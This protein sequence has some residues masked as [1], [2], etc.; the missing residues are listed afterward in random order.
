MHRDTYKKIVE[1]AG[2]IFTE[3]GFKNTTVAEICDKA[4]VN[5]ASVNYYF[6]SKKNLY[7][8]VLDYLFDKIQNKYPFKKETSNK[9]PK[10]VLKEAIQTLVLRIIPNN[11]KS[12]FYKIISKEMAEPTGIV[13]IVEKYLIPQVKFF[14]KI[15]YDFTGE[16]EDKRLIRAFHSSIISQCMFFHNLNEK[17]RIYY[18]KKS[19]LY[20]EIKTLEGFKKYKDEVANYISDFCIGGIENILK[21]IKKEN[22]I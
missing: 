20:D 11:E 4:N 12:N 18:L 8:K 13:N 14:E 5:V 3:K 2:E 16:V 21:N 9:N 22:G 1:F 19:S 15:L 17:G 10:I 6:G 7:E